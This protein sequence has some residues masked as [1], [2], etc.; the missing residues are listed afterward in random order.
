MRSL[1]YIQLAATAATAFV[2][3]DAQT[4]ANLDVF[5]RQQAAAQVEE[6]LHPKSDT[7]GSL[8]DFLRKSHER[9]ESTWADLSHHAHSA[10][11]AAVDYASEADD[12]FTS[13]VH[14]S[15][16][17]A[18]S[19]FNSATQ[20]ADEKVESLEAMF[21]DPHHPPHHGPPHGPPHHGPPHH[22]PPHHHKSNK[23][24]Y[25]LIA[26]SKYTTKLAKLINEYPD[27]VKSLN[28]T[29]ANYTVFAP[30]DAA[31]EKIPE[32]APKPSKEQLKALLEYHVSP[33]FY[34]AGHIL[35]TRTIPTLLTSSE[36]GGK[37]DLP[38]RLTSNIGLR[39]LTLNFYS[40]VVVV[41]IFGTNGVIHGI[42]SILLPPPKAVKIVEL[43]PTE[44]STLD[45]ALT[46]TGLIDT[47]N[48]TDHKGSTIFAPSNFAFVKLG[49]RINAFL[50]S[51]A[52]LKYLEALLKYHVVFGQT[53]YSDHI[54]PEPKE[55][56]DEAAAA[57]VPKGR[58]HYDL[59]TL[60]EGK[61]LAIDI[62]RWGR[63][64]EIKINAFFRVAVSDGVA[65]D[66]VVHVV[67]NVLIPPKTSASGELLH[68]DGGDL[69]E[70]DLMERL[71]PHVSRHTVDL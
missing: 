49:P 65:K 30:I 48:G 52:G 1:A 4:F 24:V 6:R 62:A 42:N 68:Y 45:L 46:K 54:Y 22:K 25:E 37:K 53:L 26:A 35:V 40:R 11:D 51:P 43:L 3:P 28:G 9:F 20:Y 27:L 44:F 29:K 67:S 34:P 13:T 16:F 70:E 60:L 66:G 2:L 47:L 15:A 21:E 71:E 69:T 64:I 59:P 8:N 36:L 10:I 57:G 7:L 63:L 23:T 18:E 38:Q 32:H 31:F 55:D 61:S 12:L 50:F 19:W 33:D 14:D 41:D 17:A 5:D 56:D 58:L 39:G